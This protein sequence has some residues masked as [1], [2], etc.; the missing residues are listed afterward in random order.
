MTATQP[1]IFEPGSEI[2]E[3]CV[4]KKQYFRNFDRLD[5]IPYLEPMEYDAFVDF[6][7][8]D[9]TANP[10]KSFLIIM[11]TINSSQKLYRHL[12]EYFGGEE[13]FYLST[14]IFPKER[15]ARIIR[16][17][18]YRKRRIIVSTQLVEAVS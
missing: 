15:L 1:L 13:L 5:L 14:R 4:N 9:I 7:V 6:V 10:E 16:M 8:E 3:L 18:K 11:N 12:E 2:R 17:H